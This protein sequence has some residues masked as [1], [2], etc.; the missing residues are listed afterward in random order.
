MIARPRRP[1]RHLERPSRETIDLAQGSG[2]ETA[3]PMG[4]KKS[5]DQDQSRKTSRS[6]SSR[7]EEARKAAEEYVEDL[8]QIVGKLR[9]RLLN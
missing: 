1:G 4:V 2:V 5:D 6:R 8:R 7:L 9:A 3:D